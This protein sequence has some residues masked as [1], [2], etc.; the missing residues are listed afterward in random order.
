MMKRV[1]FR[2][3]LP[4]ALVAATLLSAPVLAGQGEPEEEA[5]QLLYGIQGNL[6]KEN[7]LISFGAI[8]Q[9]EM[10]EGESESFHTTLYAGGNYTFIIVADERCTA[11]SA[12]LLDEEWK[13]AARAEGKPTAG[14]KELSAI[15]RLVPKSTGTHHIS[16]TNKGGGEAIFVK[17]KGY[18][19]R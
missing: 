14:R 6:A 11:F 18:A 9:K 19:K 13:E 10:G 17:S 5:V 7:R 8:A 12:V 15:I 3:F 2:R 4:A 16:I 1:I